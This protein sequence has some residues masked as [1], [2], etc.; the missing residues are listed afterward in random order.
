MVE[1]ALSHHTW[2]DERVDSSTGASGN[3]SASS[4]HTAA[5]G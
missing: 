4:R 1:L 2:A 5:P 3:A